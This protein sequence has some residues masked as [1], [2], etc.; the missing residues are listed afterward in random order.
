[1]L[2]INLV[3]LVA[4][5]VGFVGGWRIIR[6][7][8]MP[9]ELKDTLFSWNEFP[10]SMFHY[11]K[12]AGF[13]I[14]VHTLAT[15][16]LCSLLVCSVNRAGISPISMKFNSPASG[17]IASFLGYQD[18]QLWLLSAV[19]AMLSAGIGAFTCGSI[20]SFPFARRFIRP[21]LVHLHLEGIV[22][23]QNSIR[24]QDVSFYEVDRKRH[25]LKLFTHSRPQSP[26]LVLHPPSDTLFMEAENR[27][28]DLLFD[29]K[30]DDISFRSRRRWLSSF[31]FLMMTLMLLLGA[32]WVYQ[33]VMEW[34]WFLYAAGIV[35]F[36]A[37]GR[38]L[39]HI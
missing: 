13:L 5:G 27:V 28:R 9:F 33:Y 10:A 31:F 32:F 4:F 39:E 1:M 20:L 23:G 36:S 6:R 17:R 19:I 35:G 11:D 34:V 3:A 12:L 21:V 2:G 25:L 37:G 7:G 14:T 18:T 30:T 16:A 26:S 15:V 24:W 22:Y 8:R 38:F 29:K